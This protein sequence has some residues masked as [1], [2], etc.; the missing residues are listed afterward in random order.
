MSIRFTDNYATVWGIHEKKEKYATVNLSTSDKQQDGSYINSKWPFPRFV[1][2]AFEKI[3]QLEPKDRVK[4]SG[5]V[6]YI[7]DK[8]NDKNYTNMVV[9]DFEFSDSAKKVNTKNESDYESLD[10]EQMPF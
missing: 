9:F 10:D 2:K 7:Y 5:K 1:G 4:I 8:E 3:D 6:S